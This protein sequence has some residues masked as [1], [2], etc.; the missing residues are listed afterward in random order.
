MAIRK[1]EE[2]GLG[3][4]QVVW[5]WRSGH[6]VPSC[7]QRQAYIR[8]GGRDSQGVDIENA[9]DA[10]WFVLFLLQVHVS[11]NVTQIKA[12]LPLRRHYRNRDM[13]GVVSF[14]SKPKPSLPRIT[15]GARSHAAEELLTEW[16]RKFFPIMI[17]YDD[18]SNLRR[19]IWKIWGPPYIALPLSHAENSDDFPGLF[20]TLLCYKD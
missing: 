10:T 14:S 2:W 20:S 9:C 12:H 8:R 16:G 15:R 19:R 11:Y 1:G 7:V 4:S 17:F 3:A 5:H 6:L 13:R 18:W